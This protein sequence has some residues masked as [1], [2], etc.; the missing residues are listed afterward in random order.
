[1]WTGDDAGPEFFE[2]GTP[3]PDPDDACLDFEDEDPDDPY[4]EAVLNDPP[5]IIAG[6]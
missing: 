4:W 6:D 3:D 1:M 2:D 5:P